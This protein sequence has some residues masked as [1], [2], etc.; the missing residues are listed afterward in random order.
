[1]AWTAYKYGNKS[2]AA[3]LLFK[4]SFETR[5]LKDFLKGIFVVLGL[6]GKYMM[7]KYGEKRLEEFSLIQI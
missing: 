2:L 1:L 4:S 3:K 7:K 6:Y 5:S